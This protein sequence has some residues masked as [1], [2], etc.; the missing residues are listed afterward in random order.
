MNFTVTVELRTN[1]E[2]GDSI[3]CQ[4]PN[5]FT[6]DLISHSKDKKWQTVDPLSP[7]YIGIECEN[8]EGLECMF[9]GGN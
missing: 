9:L 8:C 1:L 5:S 4:L 6:A 2:K 7:N 3:E